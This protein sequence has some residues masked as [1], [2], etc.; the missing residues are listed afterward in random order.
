LL[1]AAVITIAL[2]LIL[3]ACLFG[4]AGDVSWPMAWA[5]LAIYA[6]SKVATFI[7][8]DPELIKER[9]NLGQDVDFGDVVLATCGYI[10]L[11]FVTFVVAGLDAVRYGPAISIPLSIQLTMVLMFALGYGF[12]FWAVLSNPFF[13]TNVRIQDDRDHSVVSSGPYALVRHPGYAGV[14]LAHL[15]VP[16]AF[17]SIW[18]LVPAVVGTIFFVARTSRE[19]RTLRDHLHGYQEYQT[20]VRWRLLPGVW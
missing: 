3:A 10:A 8:V 5:V 16:F 7:F 2:F 14:L 13:T 11:Y 18:A 20:R 12:S 19:D 9:T 1:I 17:G 4:A 15:A 6:F